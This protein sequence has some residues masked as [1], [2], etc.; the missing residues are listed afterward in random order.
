VGFLMI[1]LKNKYFVFIIVNF[2]FLSCNKLHIKDFPANNYP[3]KSLFLTSHFNYQRN[4]YS[5]EE[6]SPPLSLLW[7]DDYTGL[8]VNGFTLVDSILFFGTGNGYL[9]ALDNTNGNVLGKKK[10]GRALPAP[11][12]IYKEILY[13][14]YEAGTSGL[15]AYSIKNGEKIW[16]IENNF[17][18]SSPVVVDNKAIFQTKRGNIICLNYLTGEEIWSHNTN[19]KSANSLAYDDGK[20]IAANLDGTVTALEYTSGIQVWLQNFSDKIFADPVL[21]KKYVYISTFGGQLIK[22]NKENG[23]ILTRKK[24]AVP[25]YHA[26]TTDDNII[27]VPLSDGI[28]TAFDKKNFEEMWS[29]QGEGPAANSAL[30]TKNYVYFPTLGKYLYI[31]DKK[32]GQLL[33]EI[34]FEGRARSTPLIKNGKLVIACED[35]T[36]NIYSASK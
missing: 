18:K 12:T 2:L 35:K 16:E 4:A 10:F 24:F 26:I 5:N 32:S 9:L 22:L 15:I 36:V 7:Q 27:F 19:S 28:V 31:L 3:E 13:Q 1:L 8:A 25:L 21:D 29:F 11:P 20:I 6:L 30:V 17:S 14:T 23:E 34:K 33:Q